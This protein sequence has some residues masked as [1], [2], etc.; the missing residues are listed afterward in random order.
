MINEDALLTQVGEKFSNVKR[1]SAGVVR[2]ERTDVSGNPYAVYYFALS[3]GLKDWAENLEQ[4]QDE[5]IGPSY[6]ETPGDLRWNH[7]LYLLVNPDGATS[8]SIAIGKKLIE[9]DRS[10][11][12]KFVLMQ[13][14]LPTI[15]R[16]LGPQLEQYG[17]VVSPDVV[18]RWTNRLLD[19]NLGVIL[20]QLSVAETI[21][22]ISKGVPSK[23]PLRVDRNRQPRS[24]QPLA[25]KFI[26]AI[27]LVKFRKWPDK[28]QFG[29]G[30]VNLL[31]GSNGVG[32]TTLL[33]AIEFVY[34]HENAR[35]ESPTGAHIRVRLKGASAWVDTKVPIRTADAKQRNLEW[36]GQRDLRGSTLQNSFARFNFLATDEVTCSP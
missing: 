25:E 14:E 16:E 28:R 23:Q 20:D 2:G 30:T 7:Y 31:V 19:A 12:R 18:A 8:A 9:E 22:F 5:I 33:E 4:R 27:D 11:A 15:L 3:N 10:Y 34:C 13:D 29:L 1:V 32:K 21:R 24:T 35:T 17:Q 26:D 6:F 36:Y